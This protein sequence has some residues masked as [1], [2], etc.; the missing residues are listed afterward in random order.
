MFLCTLRVFLTVASENCVFSHL[1]LSPIPL[2]PPLPSP[3]LSRSFVR[4]L[5]RARARA[6][7]PA[8]FIVLSLSSFLCL[9]FLVSLL[10]SL[11]LT[12]TH[13]RVR[14]HT[15]QILMRMLEHTMTL[16]SWLL[17]RSPL[18]Y[19][20]LILCFTPNRFRRGSTNIQ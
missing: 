17:L 16:T 6:L 9:F 10:L 4:A 3:F 7:S 20:I 2:F 18:G 19:S 8:P 5:A 15:Q 13:A 11:S 14:A 12:R 1:P